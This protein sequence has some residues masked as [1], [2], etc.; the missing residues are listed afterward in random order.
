MDLQQSAI[1]V[2]DYLSPLELKPDCQ[3]QTGASRK[4]V[5][6]IYAAS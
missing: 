3:Q 4:S 6:N 1:K 2:T 5:A